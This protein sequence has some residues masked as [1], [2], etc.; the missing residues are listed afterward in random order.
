MLAGH[1]IGSGGGEQAKRACQLI[2]LGE[3]SVLVAVGLGAELGGQILR[4]PG[5]AD[6]PR[7]GILERAGQENAG[8]WTAAKEA[9]LTELVSYAHSQNL[10]IRF[11]TLDGATRDELSAHG[12]FKTYNFGSRGA[13]AKRWNAAIR[14]DV[15]YI[16]SDQY[17]DLANA[18]R[19]FQRNA[20]SAAH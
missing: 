17:E 1:L 16:A 6:Q 19:D 2:G 5:H 18:I 3:P 14:A 4:P 7:A 8:D 11:Y 12:W 13:V 20:D 9:R 15:D 10:W